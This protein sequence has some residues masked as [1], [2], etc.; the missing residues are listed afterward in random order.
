MSWKGIYNRGKMII[1]YI[2]ILAR[3]IAK[4]NVMLRKMMR[5]IMKQYRII[6]FKLH[7]REISTD[8]Y[9]ILFIA[10]NGKSYGCTP[11]AVYEYMLTSGKYSDYRFIWVVRDMEKYEYLTHNPNTLIVK[12]RTKEY[13]K[14]LA[15]AK[16]WICNYRIYDYIYPK[17]DQIYVQ[18]WHGTPLKCL[19]YDIEHSDN[20][21][22]SQQEI[23]EK[24]KTDAE[25]FSYLLSPSAFASEKFI[26]A[27]NLKETGQTDKVIEIGYPRDDFLYN[28]NQEDVKRIKQILEI[29]FDK[30]VLLYAPTWR[31][32]Q[33]SA[34]IG[35]VYNNPVDFGKLRES[36][37]DEWI[38]LFRAHY[39]VANSFDFEEY[40]GFVYDVSKYD[41]INE[42][43]I[44][45][46]MLITDYSSVF[47]DY[48]NL[49]RP[50]LYY[51]YDL[52]YYKD[53]LRGFYI[54]LSELPGPIIET[55]E[56]LIPAIQHLDTGFI[57]DE[58]YQKFNSKFNYLNDG[59]ASRRLVDRIIG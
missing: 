34:G 24:Y 8:K 15:A 17:K 29:P 41:D 28:F 30:K 53:D 50:I 27:W 55:E 5:D 23:R 59:M 3:T 38:I 14:A 25:R 56:E 16:Y 9:T 32:N 19:G 21:M 45:S 57:Y 47:F 13:E 54:D 44:I 11:K 31:D 46:D 33:H 2:K 12:N 39:L 1:K 20:A 58:K 49:R 42:L 51:M 18:C 4:R 43:Y 52:E 6:R 36:L 7:T 26:S 40:D 10:F 37:S 22:N 48:A 35:Y